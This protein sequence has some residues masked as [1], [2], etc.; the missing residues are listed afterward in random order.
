MEK[1]RKTPSARKL[2]LYSG[3]DISLVNVI[4][5]L[6]IEDLLKPGFGASLTFEMYKIDEKYIVKVRLETTT[7]H[8]RTPCIC[9]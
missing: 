2:Y 1:K 8:L 6:G 5:T 9:L 3:H 7:V 4:R